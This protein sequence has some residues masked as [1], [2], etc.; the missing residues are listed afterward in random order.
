MSGSTTPNYGFALPAIGGNQDTWGNLLNANWVA[1]D[2]AIHGLATGYLPLTGGGISGSLT[3][4][5]NVS[6]GGGYYLSLS[7]AVFYSDANYTNLVQDSGNWH[8]QYTRSNG[9]MQYVRGSDGQ[10]L[11]TIDGGG[12]TSVPGNLSAGGSLNGSSAN[13]SGRLR[14]AEAIMCASGA[15]YVA[16]NPAYYLARNGADGAW[17]FV[18]NN[19][20]NAIISADGTFTTRNTLVGPQC[21]LTNTMGILYSGLSGYWIGFGWGS[22]QAGQLTAFVNGGRAFEVC[23]QSNAEDFMVYYGASGPTGVGL[24]FADR[25]GTRGSCFADS[26]SD[27]RIKENIRPTEVDALSLI[28]AIPVRAFSYIPAM[29]ELFASIG[30]RR[31]VAGDADIRLGFVAQELQEYIPEAVH[32]LPDGVHNPPD[33]PIPQGALMISQEPIVPYL[34]RALQ[35]LSA[36]VQALKAARSA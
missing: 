21:Q 27:I 17:R 1:A 31:R 20:V 36:E 28:E 26:W 13:I 19:T 25:S 4:A 2:S 23:S 16:D 5:G 35:Q 32:G 9:T 14:T 33:S 8:W 29:A 18:E 30:K 11:F 7:G 15:F 10:A 24:G 22:A 6:I 34:V 12:N 3:V